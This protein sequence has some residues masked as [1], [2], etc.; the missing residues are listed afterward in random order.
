[1]LA[2]VREAAEQPPMY[3]DAEQ[4]VWPKL[5]GTMVLATHAAV[6]CSEHDDWPAPVVVVPTA[7]A[8]QFADDVYVAPPSE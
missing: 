2:A 6:V 3:E 5:L 7:H 8:K 1:M 4:A